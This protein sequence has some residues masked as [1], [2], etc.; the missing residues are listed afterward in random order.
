MD[1]IR[2]AGSIIRHPKTRRL[3]LALGIPKT[4]AVGHLVAIW[5]WAAEYFQDGSLAECKPEEIADGA[6]WQGDAPAFVAAMQTAGYLDGL[7]LHDW[8]VYQG[9]LIEKRERDRERARL[10]REQIAKTSHRVSRPSR[11]HSET[12]AGNET[13]RDETLRDVVETGGASLAAP[14]PPTGK[15]SRFTPPTAQ[16]VQAHLD[17]I[18]EERFTG[19]EFVAAYESQGWKKANGQKVVSWK[20]C[21]TTWQ[22]VRNEKE[23]DHRTA[24]RPDDNFGGG[25]SEIRFRWHPDDIPWQQHEGNPRFEAFWEWCCRQPG[26]EQWPRFADWMKEHG[27]EK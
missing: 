24:F 1:W 8:H 19:V 17:E 21:V 3:A 25:R 20:G 4:E 18:H 16:E 13:R 22:T 12:V 6:E 14:A 15:R 26:D 5:T 7:E 27:E 11:D 2:V 10:V 23:R 9:A